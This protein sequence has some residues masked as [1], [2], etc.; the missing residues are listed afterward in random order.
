M[1]G[2]CSRPAGGTPFRAYPTAAKAVAGG[3]RFLAPYVHGQGSHYLSASGI[4]STIDP[5]KPNLLLFG[6]NSP[7]SRLVGM[8][9]IVNTGQAPPV[10]GLP[11]GNDHWHRHQSLCLAN[12]IVVGDGISETAC[13]ALGGTNLNTS[14][15]WLLHAW[16]IP[17]WL[18][19]PD[20]FRPHHPMLTD[21]PPTP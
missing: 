17:K 18:Y 10:D 14:N 13:A 15:L 8:A 1:F 20:V 11:G 5:T 3:F 9:W 12:G 19:Q 4:T 6:G 2:P 7:A 21:T 16:F